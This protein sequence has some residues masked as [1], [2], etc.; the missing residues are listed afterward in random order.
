MYAVAVIGLL[1][2]IFGLIM[3][4]SPEAW[5]RGIIRFAEKPYFHI[6][7]I[8]SRLFLGSVLVYF[9]GSTLFPLFVRVVGGIFIFAGALLIVAGSTRHRQ[10]AFKSAGF[11]SIFRPAGFAA[12]AFAAFL[13]YISIM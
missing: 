2:F 12:I 9:A 13:I 7:E 11:T 6:A 5:S 1:T 4:I 3:I 8:V 10:F